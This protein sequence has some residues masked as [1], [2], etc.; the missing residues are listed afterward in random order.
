MIA[1]LDVE[2]EQILYLFDEFK[3]QDAYEING[4]ALGN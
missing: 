1:L 3:R 4:K 2:K